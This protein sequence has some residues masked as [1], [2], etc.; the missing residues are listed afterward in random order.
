MGVTPG[1]R[2]CRLG[3]GEAKNSPSPLRLHLQMLI[4]ACRKTCSEEGPV[5]NALAARYQ[6]RHTIAACPAYQ[7]RTLSSRH[8]AASVRH[9]VKSQQQG[10]TCPASRLVQLVP[11][12]HVWC[13]HLAYT[14]RSSM[15]GER[16]ARRCS[17]LD[18]PRLVHCPRPIVETCAASEDG[19]QFFCGQGRSPKNS[20]ATLAL[21]SAAQE[22][23]TTSTGG[24]LGN[25]VCV[26]L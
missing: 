10:P 17:D 18:T 25:L 4:I 22:C 11:L 9:H 19:A 16:M 5:V 26:S 21:Y 13:S 23:R 6:K 2:R 14:S 24:S 7:Q 1:P 3:R 15:D 12:R 8:E 20:M